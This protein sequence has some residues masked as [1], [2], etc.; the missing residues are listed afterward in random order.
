MYG[1][2]Q[3]LIDRNILRVR[4]D[5]ML[6]RTGHPSYGESWH[7]VVRAKNKDCGIW[8][9]IVTFVK[10]FVPS[11]CQECWKV[12][13]RPKTLKELFKLLEVQK[14]L[15]IPSKCGIE[16]REIVCGLYGGYFYNDSLEE[17]KECY[18]K[19]SKVVDM[20]VI[21]KR[22]CTEFELA[23]GDSRNWSLGN[24]E[25]E[26]LVE[27]YVI[28]YD[29]DF[30]EQPLD[31]IGN[32][33]QKWVEWAYQNGDETYKEFTRGKSLYEPPA[34]YHHLVEESDD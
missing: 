17:G 14:K 1:E 26:G 6:E 5:G 23:C 8:H 16:R 2:L 27:K 20:P 22:G 19:V 34:T 32:I 28:K 29:E 10:P 25:I 31:V 18:R 11:K 15:G 13:V 33:H 7:H 30:Q 4:D 21:L 9:M 3:K 24:S 12:V